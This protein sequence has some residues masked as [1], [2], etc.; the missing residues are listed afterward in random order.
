MCKICGSQTSEPHLGGFSCRA[1][2]AFFRRYYVSP[3][4]NKICTCKKRSEKSHPCRKCRIEKCLEVGMTPEKLQGKH[5]KMSI[6]NTPSGSDVSIGRIISRE[7]IHL[8]PDFTNWR[9]FVRMRKTRTEGEGGWRNIYE[10]TSM[11]KNDE[12]VVWRM[13]TNMFPAT[14]KLIQADRSAMLRNFILKNWQINPIF[15]TIESSEHYTKKT[16]E[17]YENLVI[18][19]YRGTFVK[20]KEMLDDE[21]LRTFEPFWH[22]YLSKTAIPIFQLDLEREE[23]LAI[24]WLLFFDNC[25][26]NISGECQE[27]CRN[28]RK[29]IF[30]ELKN[31]Q[32]DHEMDDMRFLETIEILELVE[33]AE[34]KFLEHVM[35]CEMHHVRIHE[36]FKAIVKENRL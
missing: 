29:V 3:K 22:H 10:I 2:A 27:V 1:C 34:K 21:I 32:K 5:D 23:L 14:K 35:V 28:I 20:G 26:T 4:L 30:R 13:V 24:V 31:Y 17:D 6:E 19:W 25:H 15:E 16:G 9:V 11:T 7:V 36:D 33:K 8:D 18:S 12:T